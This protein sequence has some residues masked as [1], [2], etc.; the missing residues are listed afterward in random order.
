MPGK[1]IILHMKQISY[2]KRLIPTCGCDIKKKYRIET[3]V[4]KIWIFPR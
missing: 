4:G 3:D 1:E 2:D